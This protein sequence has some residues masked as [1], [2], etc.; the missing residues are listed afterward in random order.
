MVSF[1]II[2]EYSDDNHLVLWDST[3]FTGLLEYGGFCAEYCGGHKVCDLG[4]CGT[5]WG[6]LGCFSLQ[7]HT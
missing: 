5:L 1:G 2:G 6:D 7:F 4:S 3:M